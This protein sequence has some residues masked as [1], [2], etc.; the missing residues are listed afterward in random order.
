[1]GQ[2]SEREHFCAF[3]FNYVF[4]SV[5]IFVSQQRRGWAMKW[6]LISK[7]IIV[8]KL[9]H[10][11]LFTRI[12]NLLMIKEEG[13]KVMMMMIHNSCRR[14]IKVELKTYRGE[15]WR[16]GILWIW[17]LMI[18]ELDGDWGYCARMFLNF[19][20]ILKNIKFKKLIFI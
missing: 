19:F 9:H 13:G 7:S 3:Q 14:Q 4:M 8:I 17:S 1:M 16:I 15:K 12:T 5:F 11:T 10:S 18:D 20:F 6:N 2:H